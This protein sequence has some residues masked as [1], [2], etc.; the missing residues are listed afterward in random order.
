MRVRLDGAGRHGGSGGGRR[1]LADS[2]DLPGAEP[3]AALPLADAHS[4]TAEADAASPAEAEAHPDADTPADPDP[5]THAE[6]HASAARPGAPAGR[7]PAAPA[8][9]DT[10]ADPDPDSLTETEAQAGAQARPA[11]RG[12]PGELSEVPRPAAP[13]ARPQP[14]AAGRLR[15]AHHA[16]RG[17]R[18]RRAASALIPGGNP[19]RNGL[20]SSS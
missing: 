1:L 13:A 14:D 15:P 5:E 9:P 16:A 20:F 7:R 17:G 4:A 10:Y 3:A 11:S 2:A 12:D 19:C 8:G 6:A 18:H